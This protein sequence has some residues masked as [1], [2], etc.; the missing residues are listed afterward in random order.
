MHASG[1]YII[2]NYTKIELFLNTYNL[3]TI[4]AINARLKMR[5]II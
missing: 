4:I 5:L 2:I 1:L 3:I